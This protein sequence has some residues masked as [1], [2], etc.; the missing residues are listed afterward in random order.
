MNGDSPRSPEA[1]PTPESEP[2]SDVDKAINTE[3]C[4]ADTMGAAEMGDWERRDRLIRAGKTVYA[5]GDEYGWRA[6]AK[7]TLMPGLASPSPLGEGGSPDG[8]G[9][10][11]PRTVMAPW[12][13]PDLSVVIPHKDKG[14]G[15][16]IDT[17]PLSIE[18]PRLG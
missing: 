14:E 17:S 2:G 9:A 15:S 16:P 6:D 1:P 18:W 8:S 11:T 4:E 13:I 7:M 12:Y 5:E 10:M 3:V